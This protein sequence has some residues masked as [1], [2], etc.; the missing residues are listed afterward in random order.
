MMQV[1]DAAIAVLRQ[2]HALG[3]RIAL[4]DFGTGYS[5]LGLL[6]QFAFDNIKIDRGF[7]NDLSNASGS[8]RSIARCVVRLA[9]SLGTTTTAEGVE[10]KEVSELVAAEG[11]SEMQGYL[12]SEPKPAS[13]IRRLL[14]PNAALSADAA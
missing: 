9:T 6:S 12:L 4:D 2:L 5:S 1:G 7:I 13:E 11:C 3:V 14:A 8:S 10:T